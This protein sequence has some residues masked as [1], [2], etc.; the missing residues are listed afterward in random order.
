MKPH[1]IVKRV[2]SIRLATP[3]ILEELFE[4]QN[5]ICDLCNKPIQDLVLAALDHST[6][7]ILFARGPLPIEEAVRQANDPTNLRAV[8]SECNNRKQDMTRDEWFAAGMGNHD[9]RS[10]T[11]LELE[12][13]RERAAKGGRIGGRTNAKSGHLKRI[14]PKGGRVR[15]HQ[16]VESGQWNSIINL[17]QTKAARCE[18]GKKQGRLAVESGSWTTIAAMGSSKG[19]QATN[20]TTQGRKSNGGRK[21]VETKVGIFAHTSIEKEAGA[22]RAAHVRWHVN[23]GIKEPGCLLCF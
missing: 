3:N 22:F 6:P 5:R 13:L 15:G 21:A 14:A 2:N 1:L 7:V 20:E 10:Y 4:M 23:R 9:S 19:G 17:P 11:Q 16:A 8:H 18:N 12:E